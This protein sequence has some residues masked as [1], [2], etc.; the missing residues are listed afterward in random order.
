MT[1]SKML[2]FHITGTTQFID[3]I[4]MFVSR[5]PTR[6]MDASVQ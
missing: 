1:W 4:S 3:P 6:S 2:L 5:G